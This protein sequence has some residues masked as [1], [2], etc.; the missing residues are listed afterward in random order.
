M[1]ALAVD[2]SIFN[3]MGYRSS[4]HGTREILEEAAVLTE[5]ADQGGLAMSWFAEHHFSNYGICSSPLLMAAYCAPRTK[6]IKLATGILVLPLYHPA[7]L[8][9]EIA[10]TDALTEG[11]LVLGIGTGYQPFEFDRFGVDLARAKSV[12]EEFVE[13]IESGLSNEFVEMDGHYLSLPRTHIGPRPHAGRPEIWVAGHAPEVHRVAAKRGYPMIVNGRFSPIDEVAGHRVKLERVLSD[14]QVDPAGLK[15]G[16]LRYC[17]VTDS[18]EEA[19]EYAENARWQLRVAT[20]LR[21]REELQSGHM[22]LGD[23]PGKDERSIE[24]IL[25]SQMIGDVETCIAR[26]IEE[27]RKTGVNH[28]SLYFQLGDYAHKKARRSLERF[29]EQVIPGIEREVGP[30]AS[31]PTQP[32]ATSATTA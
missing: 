5:I 15:W 13:L 27:I 12:F 7:R 31:I 1:G 22:I 19:R 16:L 24:Q 23:R 21:H 10:M 8:L 25:D 32:F 29:I 20:S 14:E 30:L 18:K 11:R 2:F 4:G 9:S 28:I 26:G 3:L 17:C 6:R